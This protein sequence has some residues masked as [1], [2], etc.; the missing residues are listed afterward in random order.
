M[1]VL[2]A[3]EDGKFGKPKQVFE[4]VGGWPGKSEH[5]YKEWLVS[6]GRLYPHQLLPSDKKPQ[7]NVNQ[8]TIGTQVTVKYSRDTPKL[9]PHALL[10]GTAKIDIEDQE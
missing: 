3:I 7:I 10:E 1:V 6:V 2:R 5:A 4:I 8:L 9:E